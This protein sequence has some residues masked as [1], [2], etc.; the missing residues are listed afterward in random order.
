MSQKDFSLWTDKGLEKLA[1][2]Y[3]QKKTEFDSKSKMEIIFKSQ[4]VELGEAKIT[5]QIDKIDT[6]ELK[7]LIKV[8]DFKTGKAILNW[9]GSLGNEKIKIWKY[10]Q[11][12]VFYKLLVENSRDFGNYVVDIGQLEFLEADNQDQI[13]ILSKTLEAQEAKDLSI[14]IQVV[15]QKIINL[16]FPDVSIYS[17]DLDGI[18]QFTKDLIENKI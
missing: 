14:L 6:D 2:Y 18:K 12:L 11:Q 10:E 1:I 15:Y 13:V 7:K 8:T 4:A 9:T 5:G 3:Q 17:K 16:D